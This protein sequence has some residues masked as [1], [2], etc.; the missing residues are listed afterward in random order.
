[1][2]RDFGVGLFFHV[3][4]FG[5]LAMFDPVERQGDA[6]QK[7]AEPA[8]G[9]VAGVAVLARGQFARLQPGFAIGR[10]DE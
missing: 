4:E 7:A 3:G 8:G 6:G 10:G 1:M 2:R 9:Y 5:G